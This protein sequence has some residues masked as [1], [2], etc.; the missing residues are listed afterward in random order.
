M[1]P[2]VVSA[3]SV[4]LVAGCGPAAQAPEPSPTASAV[5]TTS[6]VIRTFAI[7]EALAEAHGHACAADDALYVGQGGPTPLSDKTRVVAAQVNGRS[8]HFY[9]SADEYAVCVA[10]EDG[11]VDIFE[12]DLPPFASAPV[13]PFAH[14]GWRLEQT[15]V[16]ATV[17][18]AAHQVAWV[19][20]DVPGTGIV[21]APVVD[22]WF[23]LLWESPDDESVPATYVGFDYCGNAIRPITLA[24]EPTPC[25]AP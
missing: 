17:G 7:D 21:E 20:A 14:P 23:L 2:S 15:V 1:K 18:K 8:A 4:L 9:V 3:L 25:P 5:T 24:G 11:H 22:G 13:I 10:T 19:V 6:P 16:W 12:G